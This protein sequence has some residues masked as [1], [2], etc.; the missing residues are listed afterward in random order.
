[1][2]NIIKVAFVHIWDMLI[3]AVS[4]DGEHNTA[5]F[6]FEREFLKKGLD[7]APA[8]MPLEKALQGA[9]RHSFPQL[10]R[11]SFQGLPGLFFDTLPNG[12]S[13]HV[14]HSWASRN[15]T[16]HQHFH[17]IEYICHM[18]KRS[19]GALEYVPSIAST[20]EK[21][22]PIDLPKLVA[23]CR[24]VL[25]EKESCYEK[26][27]SI[28]TEY[29]AELLCTCSILNGHYP[30]A[31]V[32]LHEDE[33]HLYTGQ[34]ERT[35]T[36]HFEDWVIRLDCA[37]DPATSL[38]ARENRLE[39]AFYRMARDCGLNM[40]ES[41]LVE[42]QGRTHL[43]TRR[44]DRDE[45]GKK[46]HYQSLPALSQYDPFSET[47]FDLKGL[48]H[49]F[50]NLALTRDDWEQLYRQVIFLIIT[51]NYPLQLKDIAFLMHRDGS[52]HLAPACGM[53]RVPHAHGENIHRGLISV[54]GK[55]HEVT[56]EDMLTVGHTLGI[57]N[58]REIFEQLKSTVNNWQTY[59]HEAGIPENL[60]AETQR[61]FLYNK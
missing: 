20:Y 51:G 6:E 50:K 14:Y 58:R 39:Y 49:Y 13:R 30:K 7:L 37:S 41:R 36:E 47:P 60:A 4:W 32:A 29:L 21:R 42:Q 5:T 18:G 45:K 53:H 16:G 35:D 9:A 27:D 43:F 11:K 19:M 23:A 46:L 48:C 24:G 15:G 8:Q 2:V 38:Y 61:L 34:L 22:L 55:T 57:R 40:P 56:L 31:V 26:H 54:A 12:F 52:W 10:P 33:E 25:L 3:G 59:A 17:P 28:V 1:M 44:F